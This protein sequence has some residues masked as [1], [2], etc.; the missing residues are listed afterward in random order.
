MCFSGGVGSGS[1][2]GDPASLPCEG[3][4][5]KQSGGEGGG[6]V[7][8]GG[9][10]G[11]GGGVS[12]GTRCEA[13]ECVCRTALAVDCSGSGVTNEPVCASDFV[14]YPS[15]CEMMK[16]ACKAPDKDK[17]PMPTVLYYGDCKE[18]FALGPSSLSE[19]PFI[20]I[21][22]TLTPSTT[23]PIQYI[24]PALQPVFPSFFSFF[25]FGL[26]VCFVFWFPL[27]LVLAPTN[28]HREFS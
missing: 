6:G 25:C 10:G 28:T 23:V 27:V 20:Y 17:K 21:L 8:G 3:A 4:E 7:N 16:Q 12:G 11:G 15:E 19:Y 26:F 5:C 18:K 22:S 1:G 9:V 13:G 14:T 24:L 2:G